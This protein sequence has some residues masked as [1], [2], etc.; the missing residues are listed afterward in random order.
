M[1]KREQVEA[2]LRGA[3]V[4]RAPISFWGHDYPK[5]WTAEGLNGVAR[6]LRAGLRQQLLPVTVRAC[7]T[8]E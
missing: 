2:A 5:E 1:N 6:K 8:P 3:S 4:D 7:V